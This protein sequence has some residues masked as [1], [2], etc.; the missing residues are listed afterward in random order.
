MA[1][2]GLWCDILCSPFHSFGTLCEDSKYYQ[3]ANKEFKYTALDIS[4]R[5]V[6]DLAQELNSGTR[7]VLGDGGDGHRAF[8]ARGPTDIKV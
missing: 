6:L 2:R 7:A 1:A 4:E 8:A 3:K 5:N